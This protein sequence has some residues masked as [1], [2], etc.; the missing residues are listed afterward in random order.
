MG[1]Q[2][3]QIF[4]IKKDVILV[5]YMIRLLSKNHNINSF[6]SQIPFFYNYPDKSAFQ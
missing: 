5:V 2:I 1:T 6:K 4:R 3:S